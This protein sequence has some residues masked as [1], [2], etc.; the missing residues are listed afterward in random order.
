MCALV[1][2][3]AISWEPSVQPHKPLSGNFHTQNTMKRLKR[4]N[5][6][7]FLG[8]GRNGVLAVLSYSWE[9]SLPPLCVRYLQKQ[10]QC[11]PFLP[12][13]CIQ[14]CRV[15]IYTDIQLQ[16][17]GRSRTYHSCLIWAEAQFSLVINWEHKSGG[18]QG[19]PHLDI[20]VST[21]FWAPALIVVHFTLATSNTPSR[22]PAI[23]QFPQS[24]N[25]SQFPSFQEGAGRAI[26]LR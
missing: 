11:L 18:P 22:Q 5:R 12:S 15:D 23:L 1:Y 13:S 3:C 2:M 20:F 4:A 21:T 10:G 9:G 25:C 16:S 26:R 19:P 24:G 17:W 14:Q 8:V 7:A 6:G